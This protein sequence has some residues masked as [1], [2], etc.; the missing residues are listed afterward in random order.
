MDTPPPTESAPV[1]SVVIPVYRSATTLRE[2][3]ARLGAVLA[4]LARPFEIVYVEDSGPDDSWEALRALAGEDPRVTAIQLMRNSGQANATL[5][6][7]AH[8]RGQFVL[9]LDDDLQHPPEEI[10]RLIAALAPDVDVV[11]GAPREKR[12]HWARRFGSAFIHRLNCYLLGKDPSLQFTSFRLMRRPV[13]DGLIALR[14]LS[15]ALGPML[16]AVTRRII[17]ATVE[18]HPRK[19]GR[20]GYTLSRLLAQTLNNIIGYSMLPLRLLAILGLVG[21]LA[22]AVLALVLAVRYLTGGITVP[23]W[24]TLALL[25]VVLSGFN[26]FAFSI[27]GEYLLRILQQVNRTPQYLVRET[28]RR[29]DDVHRYRG[30]AP[31]VSARS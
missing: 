15:P 27:I 12:H 10:P 13:V 1:Y 30:A 17:N 18:H 3:H 6:G 24:T 28:L 9:T 4:S 7:L 20:S 19:A 25:L 16:T 23:G 11:M 14:T 26:F 31:E 8:A 2:L 21:I 22:S 29:Q 5:C